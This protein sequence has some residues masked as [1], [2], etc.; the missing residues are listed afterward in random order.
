M[1]AIVLDGREVG[2][3]T[4]RVFYLK[5]E[6]AFCNRKPISGRSFFIQKK[7]TFSQVKRSSSI[8]QNTAG[9]AE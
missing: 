1:L 2:D 3:T 9:V 4:E 7:L 5:G 8:Q 6:D